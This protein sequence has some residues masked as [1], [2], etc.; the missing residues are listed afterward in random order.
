MTFE[1]SNAEILRQTLKALVGRVEGPIEVGTLGVRDR[2]DRLA[3]SGVY[4]RKRMSG[5]RGGPGSVDE[6]QGIRVHGVTAPVLA[7]AIR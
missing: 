7:T 5:G 1:R 6:Q 4:D 2:A 3:R